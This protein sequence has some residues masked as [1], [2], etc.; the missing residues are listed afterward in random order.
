MQ[1]SRVNEK[2]QFF[3]AVGVLAG[4]I[5]VAYE[6]R[7]NNDLAEADAVRAMLAGWQ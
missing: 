7:Q 5:L 2:L 1:I 6:I 4:L 3:A